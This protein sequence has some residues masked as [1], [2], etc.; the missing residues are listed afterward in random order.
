LYSRI[1]LRKALQPTQ[2]PTPPPPSLAF[3]QTLPT[4]DDALLAVI[5]TAL[6]ARPADLKGLLDARVRDLQQIQWN[7]PLPLNQNGN[8]KGLLHLWRNTVLA[9]VLGLPWGEYLAACRLL[10]ADPFASP[11][12]LLLFCREVRF[13]VETGVNI[14]ALER[15][16]TNQQAPESQDPWLL[17][18]DTA[19]VVFSTLQTGLQA[20][21]NPEPQPLRPVGLRAEELQAPPF[22]APADA[23]ERWRRW[24]LNPVPNS[25]TRFSVPSPYPA[26]AASTSPVPPLTGTP[27]ALLKQVAVLAQQAG[28]SSSEFEA[29]LQTRYVAPDAQSLTDL[30]ITSTAGQPAVL[31]RLRVASLTTYLDR[32]E[33]FVALQRALAV[34]T[35][36]LDLLC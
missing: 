29:V 4:L 11:A 34:P 21:A 36:E 27:L 25:T 12:N 30:R 22:Q 13:M 3:A 7:R 5:A 1:F 32:I 15:I 9:K 17:P 8:Q 24:R 35:P 6:G 14:A 2:P 20:V 16:L 18:M 31:N 23:A 19:A 28:L 33:Q 26:P 10:K